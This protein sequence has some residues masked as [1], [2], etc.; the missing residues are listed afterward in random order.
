MLF[1]EQFIR[2]KMMHSW[3]RKQRKWLCFPLSISQHCWRIIITIYILYVVLVLHS[4][5]CESIPS[6]ALMLTL[7]P[8][9]FLSPPVQLTS[10]I[11]PFFW[12]H[13]KNIHLETDFVADIFFIIS[14][15]R[16]LL[17]ANWFCLFRFHLT[18]SRD[19]IQHKHHKAL[20]GIVGWTR[21]KEMVNDDNLFWLQLQQWQQ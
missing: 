6:I 19:V 13:F 18:G 12:W 9:D 5:K 17:S 2:W 10:S 16:L 7:F 20:F 4:A 3:K 11:A 21:K 8:Y 1:T 15:S 14:L